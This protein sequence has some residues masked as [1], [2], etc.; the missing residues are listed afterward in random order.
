MTR[1]TEYFQKGKPNNTVSHSRYPKDPQ[2]KQVM[3]RGT[4]MT[5]VRIKM[6]QTLL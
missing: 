5:V 3:Q 4:G 6:E 2:M 1:L